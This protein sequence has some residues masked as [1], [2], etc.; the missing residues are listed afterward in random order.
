MHWSIG[1]VFDIVVV[2]LTLYNGMAYNFFLRFRGEAIRQI[3]AHPIQV[4]P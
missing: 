3:L 2:I 1:D 4:K